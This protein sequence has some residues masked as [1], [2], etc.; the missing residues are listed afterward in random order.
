M[1][2]IATG[3]FCLMAALCSGAGAATGADYRWNGSQKMLPCG[4]HRFELVTTC[5]F[6]DNADSHC[7]RQALTFGT[8]DGTSHRTMTIH[9][10]KV[11]RGD[12]FVI[13]AFCVADR[14][15][16]YV[17][18]Q[19]SNFGS[20]SEG[21]E[22]YDFFTSDGRYLGSTTHIAR[23]SSFKRRDIFKRHPALTRRLIGRIRKNEVGDGFDVG[24][25][26]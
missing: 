10:P 11:K 6:A 7:F 15:R 19:G 4:P 22:W 23:S 25:G 18:L 9:Y 12:E 17:V 26:E 14:S 5:A 16:H 2:R 3:V 21:C 20:C 24:R 8:A 13:G 1:N